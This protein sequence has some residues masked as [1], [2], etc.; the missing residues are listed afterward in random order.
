MLGFLFNDKECNELEYMIKKELEEMLLDLSDKR[1]DGALRKAIEE[2]YQIVFRMF[3]RLGSSKEL[4]K[5]ARN[6]QYH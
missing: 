6:R 3:S 5:Y 4:S 2:R 1:I